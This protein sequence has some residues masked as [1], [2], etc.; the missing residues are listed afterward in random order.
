ML[1][2]LTKRTVMK[3]SSRATSARFVTVQPHR[4]AALALY[5]APGQLPEICRLRSRRDR[6][7]RDRS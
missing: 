7:R 5:G 3:S 1:S 2:A 4:A 6:S